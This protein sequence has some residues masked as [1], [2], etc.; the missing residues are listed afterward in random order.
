MRETITKQ[1]QNVLLLRKLAAE[2]AYNEKMQPLFETTEY[3]EL[4]KKLTKLLIANARAESLGEKPNKTLE[5][6]LSSQMENLKRSAGLANVKIAYT[7]P[8]CKD[9]GFVDGQVCKC[10]KTEISKI[11][12]QE[13]GFDKLE[14]FHD[15]MKTCEEQQKPIYEKMQKWCNKNSDFNLIF[16]YGRVGSG[17]TFLTKC[18]TSELIK[19]GNIVKLTTAFNM[20]QDFKQF[21]KTKNEELLNKYTTPEVLVIDD[22][23]TEP[24]YDGVTIELLYL[25]INERKIQKKKTIITSNL[26]PDDLVYVYDERVFSRIADYHT[27]LIFEMLSNKDFRIKK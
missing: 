25:V 13:S 20:N 12:L 26:H 14:D 18:M 27:S 8:L 15:A 21:S 11:L 16:V 4:N 23:G 19:N 10:L 17:K 7:C 2:R 9:E 24:K 5:K 3:Q 22:L 6:E 1:A